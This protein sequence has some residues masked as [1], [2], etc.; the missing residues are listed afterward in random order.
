MDSET[1][2]A[3]KAR[4]FELDTT[5]EIATDTIT[6]AKIERK[7]IHNNLLIEIGRVEKQKAIEAKMKRELEVAN[8][9]PKG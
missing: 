3:F 5:I 4:L 7:S 8:A 1:I 9:A 2:L 6:T